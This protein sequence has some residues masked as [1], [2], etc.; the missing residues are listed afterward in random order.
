MVSGASIPEMQDAIVARFERLYRQEYERVCRYVYRMLGNLDESLEVVNDSFLRLL[1]L[2]R[3]RGEAACEPALLFRLARNVA[4]DLLRRRHVSD[5]FRRS[6]DGATVVAMPSTPE[7]LAL[8]REESGLVDRALARLNAKQRD[9]LQLRASGL[10]YG[11]IAEIVGLSAQSVGPT[12]AR[13]LRKFRLHYVEP[14][15]TRA[16]HLHKPA[17]GRR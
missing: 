1:E 9:C 13:A 7:D 15:E 6:T 10:S 12:L 4:I 11:E 17:S 3:K 16:E 2:V 14:T 8:R 5:A